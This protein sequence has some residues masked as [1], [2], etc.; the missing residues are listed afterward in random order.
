MELGHLGTHGRK[1]WKLED[2]LAASAIDKRWKA[3]T[4]D[5]SVAWASAVDPD[6]ESDALFA[7][8]LGRTKQE[9]LFIGK[10]IKD[11]NALNNGKW[12]LLLG[13]FPARVKRFSLKCTVSDV[14]L[15]PLK[16]ALKY[17]STKLEQ[18]GLAL[19]KPNE[20]PHL[21]FTA[22]SSKLDN[23]K[24]LEL[25]NVLLRVED[26]MLFSN[27]KKFF[28]GYTAGFS[29]TWDTAWLELADSMHD[30]EEITI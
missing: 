3:V 20:D 29:P 11:K 16:E 26:P 19:R 14:D 5:F 13:E 1:E 22:F 28:F 8:I 25:V 9:P 7:T 17:P 21:I 30:V 24:E 2:L 27:V 18:F 10:E 15:E 4:E 23:L 6:I 12:T